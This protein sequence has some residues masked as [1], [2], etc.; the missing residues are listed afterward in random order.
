MATKTKTIYVV[1]YQY[2]EDSAYVH[3]A[4]TDKEKAQEWAETDIFMSVEG[5]ELDE[6]VSTEKVE[7]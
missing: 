6:L 7:V 1:L 2:H 3:S 4:F 5:V